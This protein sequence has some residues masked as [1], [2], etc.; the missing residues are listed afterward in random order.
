MLTPHEAPSSWKALLSARAGYSFVPFIIAPSSMLQDSRS[1]GPTCAHPRSTVSWATTRGI[2][3]RGKKTTRTPFGSVQVDGVGGWNGPAAAGEGGW[4]RKGASGAS[5]LGRGRCHERRWRERVVR[6]GL[7]RLAPRPPQLRGYEEYEQ[8]QR[9]RDALHC[10]PP[11]AGRAAPT[12]IAHTG[13]PFL[14]STLRTS[15]RWAGRNVFT[16]AR[17]DSGVTACNCS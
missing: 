17:S 4:A 3:A 9:L 1:S 2:S 7:L 15:R 11:D 8:R 10:P 5:G 16:A 14:G 13:A 12:G 6:G